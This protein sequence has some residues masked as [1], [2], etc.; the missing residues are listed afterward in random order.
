MTNIGMR[1]KK[2][3]KENN[4][5]QLDF[6]KRIGISQGTLSEIE[7]GKFKPSIDTLISICK[8]FDISSDWILTGKT[9]TQKVKSTKSNL[10]KHTL[11]DNSKLIDKILSDILTHK[12]NNNN[13]SVNIETFLKHILSS[14]LNISDNKINLLIKNSTEFQKQ[15]LYLYLNLPAIDQYEININLILKYLKTNTDKFIDSN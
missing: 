5:K 2:I 1:I 15:F 11:E 14:V 13:N 7:N 6:S 12:E 9:T 8:Q 3:R 10:L 4:M